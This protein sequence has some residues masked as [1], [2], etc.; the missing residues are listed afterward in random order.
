MVLSEECEH[1][2]PDYFLYGCNKSY[3]FLTRGCI[4]KCEHCVVP[5]KEGKIRANADIEEFLSHGECIL[6]DN[7]VL[8]HK[9]GIE[10]IEKIARLGIKVDFNQGLDARLIDGGIA[11]RLS[12]IKWLHPVRLACDSQKDMQSLHRAVELLRWYNVTPKKYFVYMI[13]KDID[14]AMERAKFIKGLYCDPWA[15]PYRDPKADEEPSDE[16]KD[17]ARWANFGRIF[18]K[19][20]WE[21]Y[22]KR[23]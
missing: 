17:F 19:V 14:E 10:Q 18:N 3:G 12:V 20:S 9:H 13:V 7:N 16:V 22:K 8:A 21:D 1:V 5:E 2:M 15:Q 6:L 4:R 11:K 23:E